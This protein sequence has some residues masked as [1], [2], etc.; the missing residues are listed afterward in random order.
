MQNEHQIIKVV[1]ATKADLKNT[2]DL[3]R[4]YIPFI[5][6]EASKCTAK[7]FNKKKDILHEFLN[8]KAINR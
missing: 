6:S 3:I 5:W 1:Y 7:F 2:D 8:N 4:D